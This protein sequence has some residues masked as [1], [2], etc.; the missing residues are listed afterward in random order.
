[1]NPSLALWIQTLI[2]GI[3]IIEL[4]ITFMSLLKFQFMAGS[5]VKIFLLF[6]I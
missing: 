4:F 2:K 1:M 3:Q 6:F 5:Y